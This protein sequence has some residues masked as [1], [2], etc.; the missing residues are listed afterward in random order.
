MM[1]FVC[2]HDLRVQKGTNLLVKKVLDVG[3]GRRRGTELP[4]TLGT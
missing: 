2:E 1:Y 4:G 3:G